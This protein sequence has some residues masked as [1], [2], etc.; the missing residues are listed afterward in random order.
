MGKL[1][2]LRTGKPLEDTGGTIQND[3]GTRAQSALSSLTPSQIEERNRAAA[4]LTG[5][6]VLTAG[7]SAARSGAKKA[8]PTSPNFGERV[9]RAAS[10]A[11]KT[12]AAGFTN[13]GGSVVEGLN[14]AGTWL[15]SQK[16]DR[17]AA[18]ARTYLARYQQDL[19]D[20]LASGDQQAAKTARLRMQSAQAR[21]RTSGEL[22][23][24]YRSVGDNSAQNVYDTAD[25]LAESGNADV[26]RAKSGLGALGRTVVDVGVA[27]GQMLADAGLGALTGG[28]ALVPMAVRSFGGGAQ[29][30]RQAGATYGQQVAYGLG[31]GAVSVA[32]EKLSNV[33]KPFKQMFGGGVLDEAITKAAGRLGQTAAGKLVLSALSE[34][35]EE[36]VEDLVQPI[37]QR[38]TYDKEALGQYGTAE[39]WANALYDGLIG[40]VLGGIGAGVEQAGNR[41]RRLANAGN[42]PENVADATVKTGERTTAGPAQSGAE[43]MKNA[44]SRTK[45]AEGVWTDENGQRN[46]VGVTAERQADFRAAEQAAARYGAKFRVERLGTGVFGQYQGGTISIDPNA[47]HPV[48]QVLVHELTHHM[49]TSGLYGD[50]QQM[51]LNYIQND[52]GADLPSL[53]RVVM[54]QYRQ[55]GTE[56]NEAGADREI[57]A[58]FADNKLFQD[59]MAINRLAQTNRSL[60]RRIYDWLHDAVTRLTGTDEEK[61]LRRA[62]QMYQKALESADGTRAGA[63]VENLYAGEHSQ[64]ANLHKLGQ[65]EQMESDGISSEA[66]R[67]ETGWFRG[68]DGKWR[69]EIDDSGMTYYRGGDAAFSRNHPDYAEYQELMRT[70][71]TGDMTAEKEAHLQRLD[72][73]WGQEHG[74]LSE[75]VERGSATLED[76]LDHEGLFRAYPQLRRTKVE[77]A[78]L[79]KGTLGSYSPSQNL[80]TLSRELRS[81]PESTLVHE[82]QHAI[83][84]AEGFAK[85]S[86]RQY[87]EDKLTSGDEIQSKGFQD[88]R[89]KLIQFQLDEAN[90]EALRLK[91][92]IEKAGAQDD[93][94][95]EY[96]RLWKEAEQRG[97]DGKINE[98]YEL[99]DNYYT[100]MNRPGNSVPSELYY[101]TAGEIEARDVSVRRMLT[102]EQR[103]EKSPAYG[104]ENTVFADSGD[105]YAMSQSEQDSVKD[106]LREHQ[107][108]LNNMKAVATVCDNGWKG[109]S[110]GV[111][112]HKIVNDLKKTGY[113]VDNPDIGV[114]EFD[115]KLL[116]RS[117]NYIQTDAEAAAY[118]ALPQVL[119]RGIEISGHGG[120][121][122]RGYETL[123]IAAPVELNGKRGNM[124]VVVMR[125]KGNRYKVHRILTPEGTAFAL[126]EMTNAEPNTVGTFTNGS[127]SLG[128]SAP[129]ISSA[130]E[131]SVAEK[132]LPVKKQFSRKDTENKQ[133]FRGIDLAETIRGI[134]ES[135]LPEVEKERLISA[136]RREAERLRGQAGHETISDALWDKLK[137]ASDAE[138][139]RLDADSLEQNEPGDRMTPQDYAR[140]AADARLRAM[141][142]P[143]ESKREPPS[144]ADLDELWKLWEDQAHPITDS[145]TRR[146][147][148]LKAA[149]NMVSPQTVP[150]RETLRKSAEDVRSYFMRKMV[151]AGDSVTRIEKLV[152]DP[153]L[154]DFY[155]MAR[156]SSSAGVNMITG[157]QTNISGKPVGKG[158][159]A[160]FDPIRA[161]G[162]AYYDAFQMYLLHL[163]NIDR[164][165]I[166][167]GNN[168]ALLEAEKALHEFDVEHPDVATLTEARLA[169]WAQSIAPD[170]ELARERLS[171]LRKVNRAD[172]L[173]N[174]PVFGYEV[175]AEESRE[176]AAR[177]LR[178]HPEFA[179]LQQE[180]RKYIRNL[181]QYRVDS[182]LRTK[183]DAEFLERY[184]PNYVPSYRDEERTGGRTNR[185]SVRIGSTIGRAVGGDTGIVPLHEALGRQT[186]SVVREGSKNRFGQRLL[187]AWDKNREGIRRY[188]SDVQKS[189][190]D[191]NADTFDSLDEDPAMQKNNTFF[192]YEDGKLMEMAV[193]PS[194]F[195]DFI[196]TVGNQ[197]APANPLTN[198]ILTPLMNDVHLFD[199]KSP[200][201]TWYGGDIESQRLQGYAPG[202]RYD[203]STDVFS[204]WLGRQLN[205]SP[206]KINYLLDQYTGVVGDF[207]LPLLTP[208]A[209][210]NPLIKAFTVDSVSSNRISGDFYDAGDAITY[211]RNGGDAAMSVV[212]RYWN[213]QVSA[214]GDIYKHIREIEE[215]DRLSNA[216][217][218]QQVRE[219]KAILNG[220]QKNALDGLEA[221]EE[222][223]RRHLTGT[224]EDEIDDA[225]REANRE[226]FGPEYALRVYSKD[227]YARAQEA[228][229]NGVSYA[230]FYRYYFDT[231]DFESTDEKSAAAQKMEYLENANLS[232]RT[233]AELYFA[234]LAS[235]TELEK[236]AELEQSCG[237]TSER[238]WQYKIAVKGLQA[239]KDADGN[240]ISGTK[241]VKV[242]DAI[243]GLSL[244]AAQKDAL[245]LA[246]GYSEKTLYE[247]PW[248]DIMPKLTGRSGSSY[249][250]RTNSSGRTDHRTGTALDQYSIWNYALR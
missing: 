89:E 133:A 196:T 83:Q 63:E 4:A 143:P 156:A 228:N 173:A 1:I 108:T 194:L 239:D 38:A 98:Y 92:R 148:A 29:E 12:Y 200:G 182:G 42:G 140:A 167:S 248:H 193:D 181:M 77:F 217:K 68:M 49:E 107:D 125:T 75:R 21:L 220:I 221:Y 136:H 192:V 150:E 44:A 36:V 127:Q 99:R 114:V 87:W 112:R 27:G 215:S 210:Q 124:A 213:K 159:N 47:Q 123:T 15:Q 245:Y 95:A 218:R 80:I 144:P 25:W 169:R 79:P 30:A 241:R 175:S 102:A 116:N 59:E 188:I 126:P 147:E 142:P 37:L 190:A 67:K 201:K 81:A 250:G 184:Y 229:R 237:I 18:Q 11:A 240:P 135:G 178:E 236:A 7:K 230:A 238:Y 137:R 8:A 10:G 198:N 109:M 26:E 120:H 62:E 51:V 151:D 100:Q 121:K 234:N 113:R 219:A 58:A 64:K 154:Y 52:M 119:K 174:K 72:E 171:L 152:K 139:D 13:A 131:A 211:A 206:K 204:K 23:D 46:F 233:K 61:F 103:V 212:S 3:S 39:Y 187:S 5:A 104:D 60:F 28:S 134:R 138:N 94:L 157:E 74:R 111:F 76:I 115:E 223:A 141:E 71:M 20:A 222:A 101:N 19:H 118:Q 249:S 32:T 189:E 203:T 35:G 209:E 162:G 224:L 129:A 17:Q 2:S 128:G 56:L 78:D 243:N 158:L 33:A 117:L 146:A 106:Q 226:C 22:T 205:L 227:V 66:I 57:V 88:A 6:P 34:G 122:G 73:T 53:R 105:G 31:S 160:I 183:A 172:R 163:H 244:T 9:S 14:R 186:M 242:L 55:G 191:F 168:P 41:V 90:E 155:N 24:Y 235:D 97:L 216:E 16:D 70:W 179:E 43:G 202:E 130:F 153:F 132:I 166:V 232:E 82:I 85:G 199:P 96:D 93:D 165:S 84:N 247:T 110:T 40:G 48:R 180:V 176:T 164:M 231:R 214:C 170:A 177:L 149:E 65:A 145:E 45:A 185:R 195:E 50:F 246:A 197:V 207:V 86:N 208:R 161:K 225:Y 69:W 54:E 91:D